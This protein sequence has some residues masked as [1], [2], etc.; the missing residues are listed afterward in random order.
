MK[1]T[2]F[3][4][5]FLAATFIFSSLGSAVAQSNDSIKRTA[6]QPVVVKSKAEESKEKT[7][8]GTVIQ[9]DDIEENTG[10]GS[11]NTLFDQMPSVITSSDAGSG[12]GPT[13]FR[14]RGIDQTR[15]NIM[16]NG[17]A[18]N[19][20]ESHGGWLVN[21][22]DLWQVVE[23]VDLQRGVGTSNNGAAAFGAS[24]NFNTLEGDF[25]PRF[26][27]TSAAGSFNT[28]R[29]SVNAST[30]LIN[31]RIMSTVS[32]SNILSD[33]Y[34][35]N[36]SAKLN[37]LFFTT[38]LY[39]PKKKALVSK[40]KFNVIYGNQKTGLSWD[41]LPYDSLATNRT[42]N[43]SGWYEDDNGE[44][45]HYDNE[46]D[47][48]EQTHF[49][50][51]YNY[52]NKKNLSMN[53]GGHLTRGLG[54]YEQ[55]KDDKDF[56]DYGWDNMYIG[57]DTLTGGD[58][59]T[60]KYLDNYFYGF[61]FDLQQEFDL[62]EDK[63]IEK[64]LLFTYMIRS[65][66]NYYDG[67][68]YGDIV[69]AQYYGNNTPNDEWYFGNGGKFQGNVA[70]SASLQA[71]RWYFYADLQYRMI[72]YVITGTDDNLLDISQSY[73]WNFFNPKAAVS[74]AWKTAK[75]DQTAYFSFAVANREPTRSDLVDAT[76]EKPTFETLYDFELGYL[77]T[78]D[79]VRFNANGYYMYYNNQLVLTG[80]VNDV[81]SAIMNNV[82]ES[83]RLGIELSAQYKISK[84]FAWRINGNLSSN[85]IKNYSHYTET[86][87]E[88]WNWLG[89]TPTEYTDRTISFSPSVVAYNEFMVTPFTNFNVIFATK[90]VG[91]QYI[92]NANNETYKLDAYCV[93][94]L[95]FNYKVPKIQKFD[96]TLFFD[97][98]N[99][100]NAQYETSAWL[101]EAQVGSEKT[102]ATGYLAQ[103][104]INFFGG[105][106]LNF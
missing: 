35:D 76:G 52:R 105:I 103:A 92:N 30:G 104:G 6:L 74:Y 1:K 84:H 90:Y 5:V 83:Y 100:F 12:I 60:Q 67:D 16:L 32:Y 47:N 93:S 80:N 39:L 11:I 37:S 72:D 45:K 9:R 54:Y 10:I 77:M 94:N 33:G 36:A 85:K 21:L 62:R 78:M 69:W 99:I 8:S 34:I 97:I 91:K 75:T 44:L 14:V 88:D 26:S 96:L 19:D 56:A 95:K 51:F 27:Y 66:A 57:G 55:Y 13:S 29:N 41:G 81:G 7:F 102:Y 22:P 106:R 68:H 2:T 28:F 73:R 70:A 43:G 18:L 40:L 61:V 64:P 3:L 48:Y 46:S 89:L 24:M 58:F 59:I 23:N 38:D 79:K 98:N 17:V 20:A 15:I 65:A 71:N 53:I 101:W 87:D 82:P 31:D 49:H 63:T 4:Q 25:T 50:L 86:Y 42:Y